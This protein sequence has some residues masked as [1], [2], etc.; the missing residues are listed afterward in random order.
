[1][2]GTLAVDVSVS[3]DVIRAGGKSIKILAERDPANLPWAD[4]GVDVVLESTGLFTTGPTAR[5]HIEG[6]A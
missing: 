1:V 3:G 5:A 6:G 4:L 2:L